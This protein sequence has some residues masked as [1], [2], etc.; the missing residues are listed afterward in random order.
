MKTPICDFVKGYCKRKT[1]RLHM[2]GHKGIS[3]I[4][5]EPLDITEIGGA[6]D[7]YHASGIICESENN[8]TSLFG[9]ARTLFSTE[10]SS[11][12]IR[13]ML[14]LLRKLA[15]SRGEKVRILAARNAH[16]SFLSAIALLDAEV[17]WIYAEKDS[18]ISCSISHDILEQRLRESHFTALYITS[19]DY[20]GNTADI[21]HLADICHKHGTLLAVDN[22]H[23]AYLKFLPESRHPIDLGADICCDSAHKTLPVLTGGA[24]LH[25]SKN[26]PALLADEAK[27]ALAVFGSTSPSYLVMQSL[28]NANRLLATTLPRKLSA[29]AAHVKALKDRLTAHGY[30]L[31]GDEPIKLT[32]SAK[33]YGYR[34]D[35]LAEL[36][37]KQ[38]IVCEFCDP[39]FLVLMFS[40]ETS[41]KDLRRLEKGLL[42]IQKQDPILA[43]PP[44]L[45]NTTAILSPREA[46]LAPSELTPIEEAEGK[47]LAAPSVSC[48]PAIPILISGE[49]IHA[50]AV[51][52]FQYYGIEIC[53]TVKK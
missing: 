19:P 2:P 46:L 52:C 22:A 24:Y 41:A 37:E 31:V 4:G 43:P 12:S 3:Q 23:G 7:L 48:P 9:T 17:E 40:S 44:C 30:T 50:D 38:G 29:V 1:V 32:V 25:I 16:K 28:D 42:A 18:L 53:R 20:L 11:L 14:L 10:G 8:A 35:V 34:G 39:D 15:K 26:A 21:A 51:K 5:A 27:S 33:P 6:D 47:I 13:A 45:P 49:R 36:L